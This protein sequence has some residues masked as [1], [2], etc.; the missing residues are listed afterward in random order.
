[1]R[2]QMQSKMISVGCGDTIVR[3]A[4]GQQIF[5][6]DGSL[7][8][9]RKLDVKDMQGRVLAIIQQKVFSFSPTFEV[10]LGSGV[11]A[12]MASKGGLFGPDLLKIFVAGQGEMEAR[13]NF[14]KHDYAIF[15]VNWQIA[16]ASPFTGDP[17]RYMGN[18]Y[19]IDTDDHQDQILLLCCAAVIDQIHD[20]Q[21]D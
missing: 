4:Q 1:M 7:G 19:V 9:S 21:S 15:R 16:K 17:S 6:V 2:Y 14:G 18:P 3:D 13:G 11:S 5:A 12:T 20:L 8:F 10:K